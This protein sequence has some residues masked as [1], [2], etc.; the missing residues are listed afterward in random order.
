[1]RSP[2]K[3]KSVAYT[4]CVA[5]GKGRAGVVAQQW[6][7]C[8]QF[9]CWVEWSLR[10]IRGLQANTASELLPIL[11]SQALTKVTNH[12][13]AS[14]I[15]CWAHKAPRSAQWTLKLVLAGILGHQMC[16]PGKPRF[17][18]CAEYAALKKGREGAPS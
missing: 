12:S 11:I 3:W 9:V 10:E 17:V 7:Y 1:M 5:L 16:V 8:R 15:P 13:E 4:E 2:Y 18:S 14:C 6:A